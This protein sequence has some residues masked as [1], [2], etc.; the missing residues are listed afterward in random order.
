MIP[1]VLP[2]QAAQ[3]DKYMIEKK[4]IA[5][6][7]LMEQAADEVARAAIGL[8][9]SGPILVVCGKGNNGGDGLAAA[10]NPQN[11]RL[12]RQ[13]RRYLPRLPWR[14]SCELRVLCLGKQLYS[15]RQPKH[16]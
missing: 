5:G 10:K 9:P 2:A 15:L 16:R 13:S 3:L 11:Q 12:Y 4:R 1:V 14:R 8:N 7:L 6:L